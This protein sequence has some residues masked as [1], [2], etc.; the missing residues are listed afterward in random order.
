MNTIAGFISTTRIDHT[1]PLY[2][3]IHNTTKIIFN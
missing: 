1:Q 2:A 3:H